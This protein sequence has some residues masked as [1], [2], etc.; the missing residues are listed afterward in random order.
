MKLMI[1]NFDL[2]IGQRGSSIFYACKMRIC[3]LKT[4]GMEIK[5]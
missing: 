3:L 4:I 5:I 2:Q 1:L